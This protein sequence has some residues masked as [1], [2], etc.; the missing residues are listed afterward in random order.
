MATGVG[1]SFQVRWRQNKGNRTW[2]VEAS[3]ERRSGWRGRGGKVGG[4]EGLGE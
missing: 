3:E 1:S 2:R 4:D